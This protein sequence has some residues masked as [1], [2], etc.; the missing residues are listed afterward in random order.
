MARP[1][2][3]DP[4]GRERPEWVVQALAIAG[5]LVILGAFV[6]LVFVL[7]GVFDGDDDSRS[8]QARSPAGLVDGVPTPRVDRFDSRRAFDLLRYQVSF[9]QRPA[10]SPALRRL[11]PQLARR[12]PSG[13]RVAVPGHPG[14]QNIVGRL[15]GRR[16]AIVIAAHYDTE[17]QP[18][19]FVGANDGAA[20]PAAVIEIARALRKLKRPAGARELRF[21]LFDGEEEPLGQSGA[22]FYEVAL[23]GSKAYARARARST[24]ALILLDYVGNKGLRLP[25]EGTSDEGLWKRL[26]SAAN[27]VGVLRAFPSG[28]GTALID[29]HTPF[30]QAG[31]PAI[32]LIDFSYEHRD[33]VRDT[34]DKTSPR[35]LDVVGEAVVELVRDLDRTGY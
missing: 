11:A 27:R 31:V 4:S 9:G 23:R 26:R 21:V 22:D 35:A 5:S 16:P 20:G 3:T 18:P 6:A 12:L 2:D 28:T 19:G 33:T 30:L 17:A 7:V 14:L 32:D 10:G 15:P 29:D 8:A 34:V 1:T 13:R 25:R 24:R